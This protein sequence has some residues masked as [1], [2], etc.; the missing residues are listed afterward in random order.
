MVIYF[1]Q[2]KTVMDS[3]KVT[4]LDPWVNRDVPVE[5][6]YEAPPKLGMRSMTAANFLTLPFTSP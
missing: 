1:D 2:F 4:P 3:G 5:S 6:S